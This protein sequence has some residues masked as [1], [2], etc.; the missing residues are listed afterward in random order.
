MQTGE[1]VS[2]AQERLVL[3]VLPNGHFEPA[4]SYTVRRLREKRYRVGELVH[5]PLNRPRNPRFHRLAHAFGALVA[6][7][8]DAFDGLDAHAVLKR[9]QLEGN[10]ACEEIAINL[11]EV[12][13][14]TYRVP[15]SLSYQSM[16]QGRFHEVFRAMCRYVAQTYWPELDEDQIRH[17]AECMVSEDG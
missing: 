8:L 9:I 16:D 4:D 2:T 6:E 11:P 15:E 3:R 10:I 5:G 12:G 7:H 14:C 1:F 13:P 17:M